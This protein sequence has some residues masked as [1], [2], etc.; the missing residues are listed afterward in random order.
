MVTLRKSVEPWIG[1]LAFKRK[2]GEGTFVDPTK[3]L[4]P[5]EPLESLDSKGELSASD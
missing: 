3:W 5:N 1:W 2:H 4:F